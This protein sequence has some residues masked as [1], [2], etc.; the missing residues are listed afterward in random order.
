MSN[1]LMPLETS[2]AESQNGGRQNCGIWRC[3]RIEK[4]SLSGYNDKTVR[5]GLGVF[6]V[7]GKIK[8]CRESGSNTVSTD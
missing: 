3:K 1:I 2:P 6:F 5:Q 7:E 8:D 4:F